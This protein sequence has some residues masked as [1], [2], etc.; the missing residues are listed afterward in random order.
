MLAAVKEAVSWLSDFRFRR[1]SMHW[2][3]QQL[4]QQQASRF[5]QLVT[6]AA[7]RSPFYADFF[8]RTKLSPETVSVADLPTLTKQD[9][10][11]HFDRICTVPSLT[12]DR[13]AKFIEQNPDPTKLVDGKFF[14]I[15]TSGTS[16]PPAYMA[17]SV[18]EWIR[19]CSLQMR[20]TPGLQFR[21]RLAFVGATSSHYAGISLAL[22]GRRGLNRLFF[23]SRAL[24][25]NLPIETIVDSLN[26]F[27][28]QIL[29]AYANIHGALVQQAARGNLLIR[30]EYVVSSGEPLRHPQRRLLEETY[31]TKVIDLY[32]SS[33]T[34]LLAGGASADGMMLYEE[35][36]L[37]EPAADHCLV[38]NLFNRTFPLIRYRINDVL[39]PAESQRPASPFHWIKGVAGR[40]EEPFDLLNNDGEL[41]TI[42]A[43]SILYL[44]IPP[45]PGL[46]LV[47]NSATD[48]TF[49]ILVPAEMP[50]FHK[51]TLLR[52]T[53]AGIHN[54][55]TRK[56]MDQ[57]VQ[58]QVVVVS[59]LEADPKS[60]KVKLIIRSSS[61][62]A[63]LSR[64]A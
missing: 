56:R 34:L 55:L 58:F 5:R 11:E 17:F 53:K 23:D 2:T 1:R 16:G 64:A 43:L 54:W 27:Q 3:R 62:P 8:A 20:Q 35:D 13:I 44:P 12:S 24:D 6:F 10:V 19:G 49:R 45:V 61:R 18:R 9:L 40:S 25:H 36:N 48:L 21:R 39:Q 29:S 60:A 57:H 30:P 26:R 14:A 37:I 63:I 22:T 51:A 31:R 59:Q 41:E 4:E 32:C 38:T 42:G 33:E 15:R 50:P 46:Q 28:P 52:D 7:Q 47:L